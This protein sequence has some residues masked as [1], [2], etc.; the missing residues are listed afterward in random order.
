MLSD[1]AQACT[2]MLQSL[3]ALRHAQH[4]CSVVDVLLHLAVTSE[5]SDQGSRKEVHALPDGQ[6]PRSTYMTLS[7]CYRESSMES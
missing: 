2:S 4:P 3:G 7:M 5:A 1:L 6:S